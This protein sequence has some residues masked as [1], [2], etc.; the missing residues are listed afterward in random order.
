MDGLLMF[1]RIVASSS[2]RKQQKQTGKEFG[3]DRKGE[4]R[5]QYFK[6]AEAGSIDW[7]KLAS[8]GVHP[9]LCERMQRNSDWPLSLKGYASCT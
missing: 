4:Q 3:Q 5:D 2:G 7:I 1:C 6:A 9:A 8:C